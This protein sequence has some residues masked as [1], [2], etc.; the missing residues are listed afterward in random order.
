[1]GLQSDTTFYG[2][3]VVLLESMLVGLVVLVL[4]RRMKRRYPD[5]QIGLPVAVAGIIRAL[6]AIGVSLT[7][8][9][10][11]L[12]GGDE[13]AFTDLAHELAEQSILSSDNVANL[14]AD[15]HVWLFGLQ[16]RLLNAPELGLRA[17]QIG[18]AVAGLLLLA[19]AVHELAG[20]KASYVAAWLLALEPTSIFFSSLL[21]KEP[22]MILAGGLVAYGGARMWK[23]GDV[24]AL[25]P[26]SLGCLLA[27][28]TRPYVGWF[29]I[30]AGAVITLHA[31]GK[32]PQLSSVALIAAGALTAA[33]F[34]VPFAFEATT[35]ESLDRN[36]QAS[37][38]ANAR[39]DANLRLERVDYSSREDIVLNLPTRTADVVLRPYP[40]QLGNIEQRFGLL[41]TLVTLAVLWL[42]TGALWRSRGEIMSRAGP[43]V[44][45]GL[46]LLVAYALSAGNA[47]TAFRYRTHVLALA[48]CALATFRAQTAGASAVPK[49]RLAPYVLGPPALAGRRDR[50]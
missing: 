11:T 20:S 19:V 40:W 34:V 13:T 37:Q 6:A 27:V 2:A 12:R 10:A 24:G 7:G 28:S 9:E 35:D 29:L 32:R 50:A 49:N 3:Q 47:G 1:M 41:G 44:Y 43:L 38:D 46:M 16:F 23:R 5:L 39:D 48:I 42:L 8:A 4:L 17:V 22:N 30:T 26:V 31:A 14:T 33:A 21:H 18:I 25:L 45:V 15:L 36:L